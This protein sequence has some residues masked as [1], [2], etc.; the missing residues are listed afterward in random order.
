MI[1][2]FNN[3]CHLK[4]PRPSG[5]NVIVSHIGGNMTDNAV[6]AIAPTKFTE[7]K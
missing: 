4:R 7:Y 1:T 3:N 5:Q 2:I 6:D